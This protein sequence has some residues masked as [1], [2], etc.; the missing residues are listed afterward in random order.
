MR[1]TTRW[2][3]IGGYA[4][5]AARMAYPTMRDEPPAPNAR[6]I[7]PYEVT[8]PSGICL[9]TSYTRSKKLSPSTSIRPPYDIVFVKKEFK[10]H[11][12]RVK[13]P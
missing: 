4:R 13:K 8:R 9:T 5:A 12:R 7:A 11:T 2:A 1:L 3:G 6:A 10:T